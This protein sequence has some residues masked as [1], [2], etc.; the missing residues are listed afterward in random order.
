MG[1]GGG[2]G[3]DFRLDNCIKVLKGKTYH[4]RRNGGLYWAGESSCSRSWLA[5]GGKEASFSL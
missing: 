5:R 4:G 2:G 3:K 1:E